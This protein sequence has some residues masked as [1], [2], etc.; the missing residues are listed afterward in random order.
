MLYEDV[1]MI[2]SALAVLS[3]IGKEQTNVMY[4]TVQ[5]VLKCIWKESLMLNKAAKIQ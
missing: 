5:N 4:T 2:Y 3:Q 1:C